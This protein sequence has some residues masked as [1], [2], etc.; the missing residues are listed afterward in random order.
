MVLPMKVA[1]GGGGALCATG[2]PELRFKH[3]RNFA[4]ATDY[5]RIKPWSHDSR[6]ML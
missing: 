6:Q 5:T 2:N 4:E 3:G 1:V